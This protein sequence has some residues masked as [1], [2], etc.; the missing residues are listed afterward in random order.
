MNIPKPVDWARTSLS[1][2]IPNRNHA[3]LLP[4]AVEALLSQST[5]PDEIIVI[6]DASTDESP[7]VI[8]DLTLKYPVLRPFLETENHGTV[9]QMNR[10]LQL[11]RGKYIAFAA[12]DDWTEPH[13]LRLAVNTLEAYP[14]AAF[15]CAET[16]LATPSGKNLG[17]RPIARPSDTTR[18]FG[19]SDVRKLINALDQFVVTSSAVFTRE[20]LLAL[21]GFDPELKSMADTHTARRLA[22]TYGFC[23]APS[24]VGTLTVNEASFSRSVAQDPRSALDLMARG[25]AAIE[26]DPAHPPGYGALFERRWRF[27]ACRLAITETRDWRDFVLTMGARNGLDRS[28][29]GFAGRLPQTSGSLLA[30]VWLTLRLRPYSIVRVGLT[31]IRRIFPGSGRHP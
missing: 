9:A 29:L 30:L 5:P 23:F 2:V 12:S 7:A 14:E 25:R 18:Y 24:I 27:T 8:A 22:L 11:A 13:F 17:T 3:R 31:A 4:R 6:D 26:A 21:G 16:R 20:H 10:G 19:P 1:V 28:V 15:F